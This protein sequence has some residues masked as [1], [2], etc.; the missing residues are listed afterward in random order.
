MNYLVTGGAGFLGSN[1]IK[2]LITSKHNIKKIYV[3][4]NLSRGQID[5]EFKKM[6]NHKK[7]TFISKSIADF[8]KMK[9]KNIN[10]I[11]HFA[12]ILGV[13]R[14]IN[15]PYQVLTENISNLTSIAEIA[16]NQKKL[17]K[18]IFTSTSE[19]YAKSLEKKICKFPTPENIDIIIDNNSSPRESYAISKV[20]S[21]KIII[22][23]GLPYIILRPHN[24]F[25]PRMGFDH[26]IP[27]LIQKFLK[28]KHI[29]IVNANHIRSFCFIDDAINYIYNL[30][31]SKIK[32][33]TI[34][35]GSDSN[36]IK[37]FDLANKIKNKLQ[38]ILDIKL[39]LKKA[40]SKNINYSPK[41]RVPSIKKLKRLY[42]FNLVETNFEDALDKTVGWYIKRCK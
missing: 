22:Y 32:N 3:L 16:K 6:I 17:K 2:K 8:K 28:K 36:K 39:R 24:I 13:K 4:D 20:V 9:I 33:E 42:N 26:V 7:I 18:I 27:E 31:H 40:K 5:N 15:F 21:E 25:G 41:K 23:S 37:I 1:L 11:F 38:K 12:A 10:Y 19:V 35:I 34:N 29:S 14:V 30:S